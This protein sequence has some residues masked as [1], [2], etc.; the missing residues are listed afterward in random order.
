M[1]IKNKKLRWL[2]IV[3]VFSLLLYAC[4]SEDRMQ[5]LHMYIKAL[6]KTI[7][8]QEK[9]NY[10]ATIHFPVVA[11]FQSTEKQRDPF[12][13][14]EASYTGINMARP[15]VAFAVRRYEFIG[16]VMENG[17]VWA[18]IRAPDN[19]VYQLTKND[20]IGNHYGRIIAIH[21]DYVEIEEEISTTDSV[22]ATKNVVILRLKG[23]SE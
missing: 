8:K 4:G 5:D 10:I 16:T 19:K 23:R 11:V 20:Q 21:S 3:L 15:L 14:E 2:S 9:T 12:V 18:V 22:K 7:I 17:Q 1:L 13:E 6:Q